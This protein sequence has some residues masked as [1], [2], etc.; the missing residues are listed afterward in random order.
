MKY[1]P[2][3]IEENVNVSKGSPLKEFFVLSSGLLVIVLGT[4]LLLGLVVDW[5]APWISPETERRLVGYIPSIVELEECDP[6]KAAPIQKLL[7]EIQRDCVKTPYTLKVH[8]QENPMVNAMALP[9][10]NIVV[11]TGLLDK[12]KSEKELAFVL[13]HEMG[14]FQ[15]RDHLKGLGRALIFL[16]ITA[17]LLGEDSGVG[18][19]LGATLNVTELGYS[20]ARETK[21]DEF[22]VEILQRRYGAATGAADFFHVLAREKRERLG[23]HYFSTHPETEERI[24]HIEEYARSLKEIVD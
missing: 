9:G 18:E 19:M 16:S 1:T 11:F 4:Y 5:I 17:I 23:G 7:D 24:S 14:H 15:N 13:G 22:A 20:R 3:T 10:G 6:G 2:R 12:I 21:A 8:V